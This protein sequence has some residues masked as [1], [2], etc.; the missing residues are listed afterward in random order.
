MFKR[1]TDPK[2]YNYLYGIPGAVFLGGYMYAL[3]N[4]AVGLHQMAYLVASI[5]CIASIASL[6]SQTSARFGNVLGLLGVSTGIVATL[7]A[8][9]H[10]SPELYTQIAIMSGT[11]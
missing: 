7:T 9:P 3:Q 11:G 5:C 10:A 4:G 2:E 6:S 1:P 8:L